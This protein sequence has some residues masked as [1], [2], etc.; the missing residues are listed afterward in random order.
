MKALTILNYQWQDLMRSK[1]VIAYALFFLL[2]TEGIIRFGGADARALLSISNVMLLFIP[3]VGM[4]YG[5]LYLYQSREFIEVLLAQPLDRKNLFWGL[6]GGISL[7][8]AAAY[9]AGVAIPMGMHGMLGG[10]TFLS[11]M[12][13]LG[14]GVILTLLFSSLGFWIA[15]KWYDDRIK[16]LGFSLITWLFLALLY[17]G[18]ILI[19]VFA[20]GDYPLERA[21]LGMTMANPVDLARILVM[22]EFDISALMGYT[23]AVFKRFFEGGTGMWISAGMLVV[24]ITVP[25]WRASRLFTKKDF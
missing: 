24:W 7:P 16:G 25:L 22:F 9:A 11:A 18:L 6:Y 8:V 20:F 19:I 23:G 14:L 4:L 3:L 12:L 2:F 1:W 5:A 17:D 13:I 15:L 10:E 21:V